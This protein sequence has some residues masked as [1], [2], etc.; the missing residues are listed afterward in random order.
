MKVRSL[1]K[2]YRIA[3]KAHNLPDPINRKQSCFE[4]LTLRQRQLL[5]SEAALHCVFEVDGV[6]CGGTRESLLQF[7]LL[8]FSNSL[9]KSL[10]STGISIPTLLAVSLVRSSS[11]IVMPG[12]YLSSSVM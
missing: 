1:Q 11:S 2:G 6:H 7:F 5:E 8:F 3:S 12:L 9:A 10:N 4:Q